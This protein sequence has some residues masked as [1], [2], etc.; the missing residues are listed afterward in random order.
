MKTAGNTVTKELDL[1]LIKNSATIGLFRSYYVRVKA[2]Q[3][4]IF[5]LESKRAGAVYQEVLAGHRNI[6]RYSPRKPEF[7][8]YYVDP[9]YVKS[10][11]LIF[12]YK[13]PYYFSHVPDGS[14]KFDD[15]TQLIAN[16]K[17]SYISSGRIG[18]K[19]KTDG[20]ESKEIEAEILSKETTNSAESSYVTI[21]IKVDKGYLM[22]TPKGITEKEFLVLFQLI[23]NNVKYI[24]ANGRAMSTIKYGEV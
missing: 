20:A 19:E 8:Y 14:S 24:G 2:T 10:L 11:K 17:L 13:N 23:V 22:I 3:N 18:K 21:D 7:F 4:S 5:E 6:F 12:E 1:H 9:K 15:Q 16:T